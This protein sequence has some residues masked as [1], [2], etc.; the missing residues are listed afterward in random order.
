M[1][2]AVVGA[3]GMEAAGME[4]SNLGKLAAD[5]LVASKWELGLHNEVSPLAASSKGG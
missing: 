5:V 2:V 4:D 1:K 3:T